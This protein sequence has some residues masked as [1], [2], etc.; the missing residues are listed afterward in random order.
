MVREYFSALL[1][2]GINMGFYMMIGLLLVG[3][4]NIFLKKEFIANHLGK[5]S[6]WSIIKASLLGVPLP[7]CSCGVVPTGLYL[8]E[9]GASD[10][11]A[12]SFLIS[13]PQTGVDSIIATYG[14]MGAT[15][16]WYRPL[17]A[18]ISGVLGGFFVKIFGKKTHTETTISE[19]NEITNESYTDEKSNTKSS[20][21]TSTF[22]EKIRKS[23]TYAFGTFLSDI[24]V[25]FIVGLLIAALISV[26]IPDTLLVELGI[27]SG[28]WAMLVM[29]VI[30][31][32]MYICS[33]SSIPIALS[34]MA[35]G[36]SP[37]AA[38]VFLFMGPFTNV[39]SLAIISRKLGKRTTVLYVVGA[40][41]TALAFGFLL[42]VLAPI[43]SFPAYDEISKHSVKGAWGIIQI[44]VAGI[45]FIL[46][47][48]TIFKKIKANF[49][50]NKK[51]I[52]SEGVVYKFKVEGMHCDGCASG[53]R[54]KLIL[55][56]RIVS[57]DV[58]FTTSQAV[59]SGNISSDG[60]N[61]LIEKAGYSAEL[62][63][64]KTADAVCT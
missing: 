60:I 13:T 3:I 27:N 52:S 35:K 38:F 21:I 53:L 5:N 46:V 48:Y 43:L 9:K 42:D 59:V 23:T 47:F 34:L 17:A 37:G 56:K 45:F 41:I 25:H 26:L 36:V 11:T 1:S 12:V 30:G 8:K 57:A 58:S 63:P 10:S 2:L 54:D 22:K 6:L 28:I 14:L 16:A 50:S 18:F 44:V 4:M 20:E 51:N 55:E 31:L 7:L 33:T 62:I 15:F 64:L 32:P 61:K 29:I 39:A 49:I 40:I 24:S 19:N